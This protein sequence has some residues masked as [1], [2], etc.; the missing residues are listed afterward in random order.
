VRAAGDQRVLRRARQ[1]HRGRVRD[2]HD[3]QTMES[4][5]EPMMVHVSHDMYEVIRDMPLNFAMKDDGSS[6]VTC[7]PP[8]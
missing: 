5:G 4:S 6:L 1:F 3:E 7:N 8:E 2:A